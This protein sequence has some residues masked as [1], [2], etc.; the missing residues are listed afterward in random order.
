MEKVL[1][2]IDP[3]CEEEEEGLVEKKDEA[4]KVFL[5]NKPGR[6]LNSKTKQKTDKIW[7]HRFRI[8][9][10]FEYLKAFY[11]EQAPI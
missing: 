3:I 10:V 9:L 6:F 2:S 4:D 5:I 8:F 7:P 11:S 1:K